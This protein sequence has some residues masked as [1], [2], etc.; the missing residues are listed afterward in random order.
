MDGD[1][2][3][4]VIVLENKTYICLEFQV[5]QFIYS[6]AVATCLVRGFSL[7]NYVSSY[8]KNEKLI[9]TYAGV[10]HPLRHLFDR[11]IFDEIK[12]RVVKPPIVRAR[13]ASRPKKKR[14]SSNGEEARRQKCSYCGQ[15][16]HNRLTCKWP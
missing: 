9:A 4:Y 15:S 11:I 13:L 16:S 3:P 6:H 10:V 12:D 8:Y 7:Y 2:R 5:D 14:N 1:C